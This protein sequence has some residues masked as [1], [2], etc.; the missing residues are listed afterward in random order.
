MWIRVCARWLR[1]IALA[2]ATHR[3]QPF[4]VGVVRLEVSVC[5]RPCGRFSGLVTR[6]TKVTLAESIQRRTVELGRAAHHLRHR[7]EAAVKHADRLTW[8]V[9]RELQV[10][11][12]LDDED[13]DATLGQ[14]VCERA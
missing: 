7:L 4:S 9:R 8:R 10:V 11:T 2:A 14:P 5:D 12:A 6:R 13:R 3:V 1:G